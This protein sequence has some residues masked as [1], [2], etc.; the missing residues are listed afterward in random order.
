MVHVC[1]SFL[2]DKRLTL[3][4]VGS[5]HQ[6]LRAGALRSRPYAEPPRRRSRLCAEPPRREACHRHSKD[7]VACFAIMASSSLNN[8][9]SGELELHPLLKQLQMLVGTNGNVSSKLERVM[10]Y[11]EFGWAATYVIT[12]AGQMLFKKWK[13]KSRALMEAFGGGLKPR[14]NIVFAIAKLRSELADESS[15][16][17]SDV[18]CVRMS[19]LIVFRDVLV[20]MQ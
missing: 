10:Q 17:L 2:K 9:H 3:P 8:A 18:N 7:I 13:S 5:T 20:H 4:H 11:A 12:D 16:T 19:P 14:S 6:T 1:D 15:I